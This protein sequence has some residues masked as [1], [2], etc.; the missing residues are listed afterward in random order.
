MLRQIGITTDDP[1]R[2]GPA[3]AT[4]PLTRGGADLRLDRWRGVGFR[5]LSRTCSAKPHSPGVG[6]GRRPAP[7]ICATL[8]SNPAA[9]WSYCRRSN[10][11]RLGPGPAA[12]TESTF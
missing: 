8:H 1:R 12:S 5:A 4:W 9:G 11:Q 10:D 2:L 6:A 3:V 7:P